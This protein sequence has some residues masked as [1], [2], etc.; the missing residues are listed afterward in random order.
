MVSDWGGTNSRVAGVPN[1]ADLEMPGSSG[2]N[3]KRLVAAVRAGK[4]EETKLDTAV[5]RVVSL[6][7]AGKAHTLATHRPGQSADETMLSEHHGFAREAAM[8][9]SFSICSENEQA[10]QAGRQSP[11]ASKSFVC[12]SLALSTPHTIV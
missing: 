4:L 10:I 5:A 1:G 6:T 8:Q 9:V 11:L 7:L 2:V 3:D 12:S